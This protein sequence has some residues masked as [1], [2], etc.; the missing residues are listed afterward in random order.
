MRKTTLRVEFLMPPGTDGDEVMEHAMEGVHEHNMIEGDLSIVI[1]HDEDCPARPSKD[2]RLCTCE[3]LRVE[4]WVLTALDSA[5][6]M[7]SGEYDKLITEDHVEL[8]GE[9]N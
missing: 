8:D 5:L 9:P 4:A 6:L 3:V 2:M 1:H 7:A